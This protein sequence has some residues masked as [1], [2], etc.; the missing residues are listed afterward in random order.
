MA[1][2]FEVQLSPEYLAKI[3]TDLKASVQMLGSASAFTDYNRGGGPAGSYDR[4]Y[5][6]STGGITS[7]T[8]DRAT[9]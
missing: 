4:H 3:E 6:K 9:T 5:D 7:S 8:T 1:S 2:D